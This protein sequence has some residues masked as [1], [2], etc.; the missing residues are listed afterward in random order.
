MLTDFYCGNCHSSTISCSCFSGVARCDTIRNAI[1]TCARKP[2]WVSLIYRTEPTTK[3]CKNRKRLNSRKQICTEITANSLGNP[4]SESW[5][6]KKEG[7]WW[8]RF[9]EKEGFKPRMKKSEWVM[10]YQIIT[11]VGRRAFAVH[12]PMVWNSL[13]D[14]LRAQQDYESFR[15]GLKTWLFSRYQRV[16]TFVIIALY[17]STFTT[18][19][20][21]NSKYDCWQIM[22][23]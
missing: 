22:T 21:T 3:K 12:G 23:V 5:R 18:P 15:Q 9:A 19:Y 17:K 20:H 10:E 16:Q 7:Q 11:T 2:T 6:R 1:L 14:D 13:P 8:E 4:C